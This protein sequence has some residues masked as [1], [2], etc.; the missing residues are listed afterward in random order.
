MRAILEP[1]F[2]N[3]PALRVGR[4]LL[5][6]Y[7]V[8]ATNGKE[9]ALLITDLEVYDGLNDR[10]S[11]AFRGKTPRNQVMWSDAGRLYAYFV[12]GMYWMLNV[13]T[14]KKDYPAAI[15]VRGAGGIV[16]PARLTAHLSISGEQNGRLA[17]PATGVW[18]EDRDIVVRRGDYKRMPRVGV[19]YAGEAWAKKPYRFLLKSSFSTPALG[20]QGAKKRVRVRI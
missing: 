6:K 4:E 17:T 16:G 13:V 15:L 19:A 12:Y 20:A 10:A 5:G 1:A 8:R 11:H 3:R 7:L 18:F 14:G 2:F 9:I